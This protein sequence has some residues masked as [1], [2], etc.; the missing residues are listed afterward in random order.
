MQNNKKRPE[1]GRQNMFYVR[2]MSNYSSEVQCG[3]RVALSSTSPK[4]CGQ[5]RGS[6]A[7]ASG[8]WGVILFI[9]LITM[10]IAQA[11]I[12]KLMMLLMNEP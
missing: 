9:A 11:W 7:G 4:Q 2:E 6:F 3:Q 10:K 8:F 1:Q 12:M 5:R